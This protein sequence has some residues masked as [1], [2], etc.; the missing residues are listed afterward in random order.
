MLNR[1]VQKRCDCQ[2]FWQSQIFLAAWIDS[3][4]NCWFYRLAIVLLNRMKSPMQGNTN[5]GCL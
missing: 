1:G 2:I 5:I 3:S 4:S